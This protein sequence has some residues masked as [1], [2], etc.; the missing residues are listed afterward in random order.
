MA[1]IRIQQATNA[2]LGLPDKRKVVSISALGSDFS[3]FTF[4]NTTPPSQQGGGVPVTEQTST[5]MIQVDVN[6][7]T[8]DDREFAAIPLAVRMQIATFIVKNAIVVDLD[9]VVQTAANVRAYV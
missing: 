7:V 3:R 2:T 4:N 9:G 6:G 5:G 8:M 1:V